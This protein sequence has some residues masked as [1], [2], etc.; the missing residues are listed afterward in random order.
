MCP[1]AGIG[2][3]PRADYPIIVQILCATWVCALARRESGAS[4]RGSDRYA[5]HTDLRIAPS[6]GGVP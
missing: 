1:A 6:F 5:L 4:R 2:V 3:Y